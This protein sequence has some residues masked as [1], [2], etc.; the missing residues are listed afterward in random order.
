MKDIVIIGGG[1]GGC[2]AAALLRDSFDTHLLEAQDYLGGCAGTFAHGGHRFNAGAT[3]LV[4][5]GEGQPLARLFARSRTPLPAT[6]AYDPPLSVHVRGK[7]LYR[8]TDFDQF[9]EH[10]NQC[11]PDTAHRAFWQKIR[12]INLDFLQSPEPYFSKRDLFRSALSLMPLACREPRSLCVNAR[13]EILRYYPRIDPAYLAFLDHQILIAAQV[14]SDATS[15]YVAALALGYLFFDYRYVPGGMGK[16][17]EALCSGVPVTYCSPVRRIVQEKRGFTVETDRTSYRAK[18]IIL[19]RSLFTSETLSKN[20]R[21]QRYYRAKTKRFA[22]TQSA[23]VTYMAVKI[24]EETLTTPHLQIIGETKLPYGISESVFVSFS[25]PDDPGMSRLGY[26]SLTLSTHTDTRWFV[27]VD[28]KTYKERKTAMQEAV[29]DLLYSILPELRNA[30]KALLFSATPKTFSRYVGRETV[31][32][33]PLSRNNFSPRFP[34]PETP[35]E[36]FYH[37][38]D[39]LFAGQGWPGIALG[40]LNLERIIRNHART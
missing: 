34:S 13:R 27:S 1:A 3:T 8:Y 32:G 28:V 29:L 4:G 30:P 16:V 31:G 33:I 18:R 15:F 14:K 10:L 39:T 6:E 12:Q 38:G 23:F 36:G 5:L 7:K 2:A 17:C 24:P 25:H 35:L 19:N 20:V 40:A 9:I 21:M 37:V 26:R 22:H 11:F